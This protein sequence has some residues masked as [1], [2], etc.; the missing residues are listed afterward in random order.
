MR[1]ISKKQVKELTTYSFTQTARL[2]DSGH[3]PRRIR[4][5]KGRYSRVV[6]VEQEVLEWMASKLGG[7]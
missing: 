4:L 6:Y 2:E 3:F 5:G 1:F 7:R